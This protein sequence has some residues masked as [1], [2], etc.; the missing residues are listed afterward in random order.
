[1]RVVGV[2][3]GSFVLTAVLGLIRQAVIGSRF[4]ADVELDA[5]F[6]AN[7]VSETLFSLISGGALGSAF[8]PV[9]ARF[10][11]AD[12]MA[13]AWRLARGVMS[14]VALL[15][16][17]F[18]ILAL[19]FAEPLTETL[20]IPGAAASQVALT[21]SLMRIMLVTVLI[22]SVSG[23]C[24]AILN[25]HQRFFAA[26]LTAGMY[27]IGL[28]IGA[29]FLAP[30]LGIYGLAWGAV[31]GA[32]LHLGVQLPALRQINFKFEFEFSPQTEGL[33]E[34]L[35]LMLPRVL[36]L[37]AFQI[38]FW[39]NTA[40]TSLSRQEQGSLSE[41][42]LAFVLL[43]SVLGVIGQS[44]GTAVFPTLSALAASDDTDG[45]RRTLAQAMRGVIF[46]A[47][48][49]TAGLIV[50]A[51]PAVDLVFGRGRWSPENTIGT[52][53]ALAL[54][55]VGLVGFA[56]QEVLARAFYARR[57]TWTPVLVAIFGLILNVVLSVILIGVV[58]GAVRGQGSFGGLALANALTTLIES[59]ILWLLMSR[60]LHG[61]EDRGLLLFSVR[62]GGAALVMG[63][64]VYVFAQ[65]LHSLPNFIVLVVGGVVGVLAF[66]GL[67][68]LFRIEEARTI[69]LVFLRRV[70][71]R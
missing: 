20:L 32:V 22:F 37:A 36:G 61:L 30:F 68:L 17:A 71:H 28:I 26:S 64:V 8:I 44:V 35:R 43:F 24:M 14:W 33:G 51:V 60:A 23:L 38:N 34:V 42:S 52:A 7:R 70:R 5:Y 39:V 3:M 56:L 4:G 66:E 58:Q 65:V 9:F 15:A 10:Q 57:N 54:Y 2:L 25:T 29:L 13:R 18:S 59:A 21:V 11:A 48:P 55:A 46:M 27:N 47:L 67:A 49:A 62:V 6:A 41:L 12:D 1:M 45:F 31:L 69:P 50:L 53:W 40:I 63:G 19:I 16:G